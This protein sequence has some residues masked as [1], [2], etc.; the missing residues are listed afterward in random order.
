MKKGG[1]TRERGKVGGKEEG[2]DGMRDGEGEV[3]REG[4]R[5][6][7][8]ER[9]REVGGRQEEKV[10]AWKGGRENEGERTGLI[11]KG[12]TTHER[13]LKFFQLHF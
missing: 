13:G 2:R 6:R 12:C 3:G 9:E 10:T 7:G 1:R 5:G 4:R 11:M 8:M